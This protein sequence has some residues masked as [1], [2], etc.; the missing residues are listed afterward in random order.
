MEW[1]NHIKV[2]AVYAEMQDGVYNLIIDHNMH[3][4]YRS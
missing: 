1:F 2:R 4:Q 3:V